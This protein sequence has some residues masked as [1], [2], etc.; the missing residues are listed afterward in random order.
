[1]ADADSKSVFDLPLDEAEEARLDAVAEAEMEAG[2]AISHER[3]REWLALRMTG[4]KVPP[5]AH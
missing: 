2:R 5:P 3:V 4:K 1:M